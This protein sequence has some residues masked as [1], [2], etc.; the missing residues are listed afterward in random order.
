MSESNLGVALTKELCVVCNKESDGAILMNKVLTKS[1]AKKVED[2]HGKVIGFSDKPCSECLEAVGDGVYIIEVN[3]Q[4]TEDMSNPYRTGKQWGVKKEAIE[5]M[6]SDKDML[7]T[8]LKKQACF[9]PIEL[10]EHMG[11]HK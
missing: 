8:T 5:R 9:M 6:V 7:E 1:L 2:M 10:C 4:L 3:E 11:L